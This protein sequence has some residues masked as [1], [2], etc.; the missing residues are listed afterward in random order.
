MN[1]TKVIVHEFGGHC[2]FAEVWEPTTIV[3]WEVTCE[4]CKRRM[5]RRNERQRRQWVQGQRELP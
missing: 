3:N 2:E 1:E 5:E 4:F